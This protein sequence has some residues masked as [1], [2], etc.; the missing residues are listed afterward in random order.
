M[1]VMSA[2]NS[3]ESNKVNDIELKSV[4]VYDLDPNSRNKEAADNMATIDARRQKAEDIIGDKTRSSK[5]DDKKWKEELHK[6]KPTDSDVQITLKLHELMKM[7]QTHLNNFMSE[8]SHISRDNEKVISMSKEKVE[9]LAKTYQD[10]EVKVQNVISERFSNMNKYDIDDY[11]K[12]I[13]MVNQIEQLDR[14]ISELEST[15]NMIIDT[16]NRLISSKAEEEANV[17]KV[18]KTQLINVIDQSTNAGTMV[19]VGSSTN[20]V[21][22]ILFVLVIVGIFGLF[23]KYRKV[24]F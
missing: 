17:A 7:Y 1:M 23:R 22:Y 12:I 20:F 16:S 11:N 3:K 15:L 18:M 13:G 21:T 24:G 2:Y 4:L 8:F 9:G 6:V 5:R 10:I 14:K 19:E